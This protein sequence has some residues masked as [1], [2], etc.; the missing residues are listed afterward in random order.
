MRLTEV[1]EGQLRRITRVLAK[2]GAALALAGA[3][4]GCAAPTH[5][6]PAAAVK[7]LTPSAS[8][9]TAKA[10]PSSVSLPPPP[11]S[12]SVPSAAPSTTNSSA[13]PT[14][15]TRAAV[16]SQVI[17]AKAAP[18]DPCSAAAVACVSL[19]R[20]EAWFVSGGKVVR[21]P[22][23]VATG[24]AGYGTELGTFHVF[25]KNRM[26]YSTIYNNAPMPYSVFFDGGEAF[27]QGSTSVRS[28]GCVHVGASNASWI[29]NFL[30]LGDEVQVVS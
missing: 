23:P 15:T 25:R 21:G 1:G 26:W 22:I 28:H 29:F 7:P 14:P 5:S 10:S 12:T 3:A 24:R 13:A 9:S 2:T 27:H 30:H 11:P 20:Q 17:T 19:S 18:G 6:A 16:P 4:A 8:P